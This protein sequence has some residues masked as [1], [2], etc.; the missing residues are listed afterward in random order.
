MEEGMW[1]ALQIIG[2]DLLTANT[3]V[4]IVVGL[5]LQCS[6]TSLFPKMKIYANQ[7][8]FWNF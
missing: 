6:I 2:L 4:V 1:E 3:C 7:E 8:N 5:Y